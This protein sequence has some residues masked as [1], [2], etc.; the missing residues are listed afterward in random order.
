MIKRI[1]AKEKG[2]WHINSLY[3][4]HK[5]ERE[6]EIMWKVDWWKKGDKKPAAVK[7]RKER[8]NRCERR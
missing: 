1:Q 3:I 6:R 5:R 8:K 2:E 7:E 4:I